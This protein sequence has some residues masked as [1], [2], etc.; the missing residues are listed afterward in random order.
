MAPS[1]A[2]RSLARV[3]DGASLKGICHDDR[4]TFALLS[5]AL[6]R[7]SLLDRALVDAGMGITDADGPVYAEA[8]LAV[9]ELLFGRG[10]RGKHNTL[11]RSPALRSKLLRWQAGLLRMAKQ[12]QRGDGLQKAGSGSAALAES[13]PAPLPR[14]PRYARVNTLRAATLD[15]VSVLRR[16]GYELQSTPSLS[17]RAAACG[18][19]VAI[20]SGCGPETGAMW[21]DETVRDLLVL[22]AGLELHRHQLVS[23]GTLILQDKASC[24]TPEALAPRPGEAIIDCCA[25][26]GNKTSQLAA[27][28]AP[29][30]MVVA[31]ERDPSRAKTLRNRLTAAHVGSAVHVVEGDFLSI[32]PG[33]SPWKDATALLLDPSCSGSGMVER[34]GDTEVQDKQNSG[35]MPSPR[36]RAL[37][38]LQVRLL[39]H[40]LKLP[41]VRRVA[42]STCSVHPLENEIVALTVARHPDVLRAGWR[43]VRALPSWPCR[44]IPLSEEV[45]GECSK[46]V[47]AGP[48]WL[49][50][51]FFVAVFE[52]SAGGI[53]E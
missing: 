4:A 42:Y 41:N 34:R 3:L 28:A 22:P 45:R 40:A 20:A 13:D 53:G 15:V 19:G 2:A 38:A 5:E 27:L 23:S 51:G 7:R 9:H 1:H 49:T 10:L 17:D 18:Q 52:R 30:A 11:D 36:L 48:E 44:G 37:A 46:M 14:L 25:A 24:F 6:R 29:G 8:L 21:I 39:L 16:E 47:R 32:Q 50:N 26:P 35:G 31:V 12:R 43:L 33:E